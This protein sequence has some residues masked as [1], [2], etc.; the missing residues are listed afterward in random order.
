MTVGFMLPHN[1]YVAHPD[2]FARYAGRVSTPAMSV[3]ADE[4]PH[5]RWWREFTGAHEAGEDEMMRA[6]T[7]YY[8]LVDKL[9]FLIGMVLDR[10]RKLGLDRETLVIYASDHGEGGGERGLFWKSTF[11][12][13]SVRVP[14]ILKIGRAHV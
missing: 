13:E 7:A 9:D 4:H 3:P 2:D 12:E 11:Y 8:A 5:I 6:R 14:L 10:L 1:P